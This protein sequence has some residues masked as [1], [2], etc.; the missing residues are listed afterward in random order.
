MRSAR[1]VGE[2]TSCAVAS[3]SFLATDAPR[4]PIGNSLNLSVVLASQLLAGLLMVYNRRENA[5]RAQ[6]ARNHLLEGKTEEE[7]A[8]L[9]H[10]HP[11]FA[12]KW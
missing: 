9:G 2:L 8:T 5:K 4:Y 3:W 1:A 12:Y 11:D 10:K 6:G 7:I